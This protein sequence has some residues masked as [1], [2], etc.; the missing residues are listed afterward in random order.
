MAGRST[1]EARAFVDETRFALEHVFVA[2]KQRRE[3]LS[4]LAVD[5]KQLDEAKALLERVFLNRDQFSPN[6]NWH[7]GKLMERLQA[8]DAKQRELT[9]GQSKEERLQALLARFG[10]TEE[11]MGV[12]AGTV[13][14][15]AKQAL[16]F[17]FGTKGNVPSGPPLGSQPRTEVI[18][19]GRNH[20]MHWEEGR[21][22][23]PAEN[24]L[25]QLQADGLTSIVVGENNSLAIL[26]ALGWKSADDV[27]ASL[28]DLV[29]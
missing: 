7:Y 29:Q 20:A 16:S 17:R 28:R 18:W 11:A 23:T 21:T 13:L 26:D 19:E 2:L 4:D 27:M 12:L 8:L 22:G 15:L 5:I 25:R 10:A 9:S 6:A 3:M 24:M 1:A 14:Q